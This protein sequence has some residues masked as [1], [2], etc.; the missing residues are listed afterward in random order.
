MENVNQL[1]FL[2]LDI[3]ECRLDASLFRKNDSF[4]AVIT[5]R[6]AFSEWKHRFDGIPAQILKHLD[7][8]MFEVVLYQVTLEN[9]SK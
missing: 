8:I 6:P 1:L 7:Q 9:Q 5:R 4:T 2:A 3:C